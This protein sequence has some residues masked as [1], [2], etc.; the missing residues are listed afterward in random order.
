LYLN[1]ARNEFTIYG[2][3]NAS[4]STTNARANIIANRICMDLWAGIGLFKWFQLALALPM[5]LYQNGE[6]FNDPNPVSRGGTHVQAP[7]GY[8]FNDPR[9]Y[10]KLKIWGHEKGAQVAFSHWLSFPF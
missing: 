7:N 2:F 4:G 3:D 10:L 5:T 1:Y 6:D 9:L 8:A